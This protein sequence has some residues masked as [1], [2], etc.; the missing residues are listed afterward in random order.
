M[1]MTEDSRKAIQD[2]NRYRNLKCGKCGSTATEVVDGDR[3][4][5]MPGLK[6]RHCP[7]CGWSSA[8]TKRM[9]RSEMLR[10]F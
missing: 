4:G 6:Y 3:V 7:G 9:S 10:G 1:G 8:L 5:G 2:S